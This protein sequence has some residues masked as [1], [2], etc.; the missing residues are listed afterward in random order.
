MR[1]FAEYKNAIAQ[2]KAFAYSYYVLDNPTI[3]DEEYDIL[4]HQVKEY[5]AK[6][7][8][9]IL[10][11]SPTQRVGG[12]I[13]EGFK[14]SK[15]IQR[16]WSLDDVFNIQELE[17]WVA[18][19][20]K[21]YPDVYFTCSPKFDGVSLNLLYQNGS[22][23]SAATRGDG[24]IGE[25]V[26]ANA[27][28]ITSIPM[29][30]DESQT[31]EIR[32]EVLIAKDDFL[33]INEERI[34]NNQTLFAN[35]RNA[36][37]G[38]LRQLDSTI[39]AKRKL[40]FI[41]WGIGVGDVDSSFFATMQHIKALGFFATPM[42]KRCQ[43]VEEIHAYYEQIRLQRDALKIMLDGMVVMV[44]DFGVQ[45][46]LGWTIKSPRFACAYKFP[47]I[48]KI[49]KIHAIT[50]QVGRSGVITPVAELEPIEIEGATIS[51]AT[52]HNYSEIARKDIQINDFVV[53]IRSGDVIP[54]IIKPIIER[55]DGAQIPII[56]PK[57][58]PICHKE[59]LVEEIFIRCC[60]L[61]CEARIKES[62]VHF[63]SKKALNIDGLGEKI[64]YQLFECNKIASILDLY[65]LTQDDLLPLEGW[66]EKKASNLIQAIQNTKHIELWRLINA[67]GIEHI[68][69]GAS[70]KLESAFGLSCFEASFEDLIA[71]DGFG[72]EMVR[73]FLEFAFVNKET[74]HKL[75]ALIEPTLTPKSNLAQ[76]LKNLS[77]VITG[78][79]SIPRETM[80]ARLELLGAKI[81]SSVSKKT[82]Y[83]LCGEDAG[84]KRQKALELGVEIISEEDL[85]RML[86]SSLQR[87]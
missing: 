3:S 84:S 47:A 74:I 8:A 57:F 33:K 54:K 2:I 76:P 22:L 83:V 34:K 56:P 73:A 29:H 42:I 40:L 80:K 55:R 13:L 53:I 10:P 46:E 5:E 79:L 25:E 45:N 23:V 21:N 15:H 49:T 71:L 6:N 26:L 65:T 63:A 12:E 87:I 69:E 18:R 48:E 77:F 75:F 60:N 14:K 31:I 11:D 82:N 37:A 38:S 1:D 30:I 67:L 52:L 4:Y 27:K 70:K 85:E 32:G 20:K 59:L 68:G 35:P 16:M 43:G 17:E 41:P 62:I 86:D 72:E 64:V 24:L 66:K 9:Q 50:N 81:N 7:P 44:D 19:I 28:T 39:T 58:C 61:E 36:A 51:R 78:T